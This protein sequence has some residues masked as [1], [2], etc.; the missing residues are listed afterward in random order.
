MLRNDFFGQR[1][2]L[3]I[4][5]IREVQVCLLIAHKIEIKTLMATFM[6]GIGTHN[7]ESAHEP[8]SLPCRI[9]P[10]GRHHY[11]ITATAALHQEI[12]VPFLGHGQCEVDAELLTANSRAGIDDALDAAI[13]GKSCATTLVPGNRLGSSSRNRCS[14]RDFDARSLE[15]RQAGAGLELLSPHTS[16]QH[17]YQPSSTPQ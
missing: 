1:R 6:A 16:I 4:S 3:G 8:G 5:E 9:Q 14:L 7:G 12:A 17:K 13:C 10:K 2:D 11:S 15:G